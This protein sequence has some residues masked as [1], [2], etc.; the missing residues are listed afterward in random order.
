MALLDRSEGFEARCR[1]AR[2]TIAADLKKSLKTVGRTTEIYE[3]NRIEGKTA[4]LEETYQILSAKHFLDAGGT[5]RG[6]V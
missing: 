3:S 1:V 4:T 2:E 5:S 6:V